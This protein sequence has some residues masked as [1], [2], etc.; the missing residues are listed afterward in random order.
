MGLIF[1]GKSSRD[2]GIVISSYPALNHGV[3]R[4]EAYTIAGR[5]G[6]FYTEDGTVD[7]YI[8]AY[9]V[10]VLE[11]F[12]G[13]ASRA[14]D[15]AAWL[16]APGFHRL[17]DSFEPDYYKIARYAGPLNIE[18]ILGIWGKCT[19][20]FDCLPERWLKTG[21][22]VFTSTAD[23]AIIYNPTP[24]TS[25][26][27]IKL[28]GSSTL[29]LTINGSHILDVTG[30]GSGGPVVIDSDAGTITD[31][32]GENIMGQVTFYTA[33][34]DFPVLAPGSNSI[35]LGTN[36]TDFEIIPRWYVL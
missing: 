20:E 14:A 4:G 30:Q 36:V 9:E 13:A 27:I 33:F 35:T 15:I 7:N 31:G 5:N 23:P 11:K 2:F 19:L 12:R 22:D 34:N 32:S 10:A 24:Y 17:E 21:E 26:P 6:T 16:M 28:Y 18:Q 25:K 3:K 29:A 1:N 8:Q